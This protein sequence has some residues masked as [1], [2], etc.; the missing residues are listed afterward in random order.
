M[1]AAEDPHAVVSEAH[2]WLDQ[3][4][5]LAEH[6]VDD[7]DTASH[8]AA[9]ADKR[10]LDAQADN[11]R[12]SLD[13]SSSS[14]KST[15]S[16]AS[17]KVRLKQLKALL[18]ISRA[19]GYRPLSSLLSLAPTSAVYIHGAGG[20]CGLKYD[21]VHS[22]FS[23]FGPIASLTLIGFLPFI[24]LTFTHTDA[25]IACRHAHHRQ[26]HA[27]VCDGRLLFVEY[28]DVSACTLLTNPAMLLPDAS[29]TSFPPVPGLALLAEFLSEE[30]EAELL[31]FLHGHPW[32][33]H[34]FRSVQHFGYAFDY[35]RNDVFEDM[36]EHRG[37]VGEDD[38]LH[39]FPP[40]FHALIRRFRT[41]PSLPSIAAS[42]PSDCGEAEFV[43][44]Q[45]TV[46]R[47][48]PGDGIAAHVD[49]HSSF[50][51]FVLSLSL[52]SDITMD[53]LPFPPTPDQPAPPSFPL[54]LPRRSLLLLSHYAR[55]GCQHAIQARKTDRVDGRLVDRRERI[56][57]TFRRRREGGEC[58]CQWRALCDTA[59]GVRKK[60]KKF[61]PV[62]PSRHAAKAAADDG[63][64]EEESKEQPTS[65][66]AAA[67]WRVG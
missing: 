11:D 43:P 5:A 27:H 15:S 48:R 32:L 6:S 14:L 54:L 10:D 19:Q 24:L 7:G 39:M 46:N 47:Y 13:S 57:L 3:Q 2:R 20:S 52:A 28:A 53:I 26:K 34:K 55:Y 42:A 63:G 17:K 64:V 66:T 33:L 8:A 50:T 58:R 60:D 22:A 62:D 16:R 12:S 44:N 25:A 29:S 41:L 1:A 51:S 56:S 31:S 45:L 9:P 67:D 61:L 23:A 21:D 59:S 4:E 65:T 40:V 38:D 37:R 18:C 35:E 30:E 36:R 49:V